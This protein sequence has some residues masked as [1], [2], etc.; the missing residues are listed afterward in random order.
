MGFKTSVRCFPRTF[1]KK[2][3]GFSSIFQC[4]F[5]LQFLYSMS[6]IAATRAEGGLVFY[7]PNPVTSECCIGKSDCYIGISECYIV[8]LSLQNVS[9]G[10]QKV[11]LLHQ[12]LTF[13]HQCQCHQKVILW[14]QNNTLKNCKY[15]CLRCFVFKTIKRTR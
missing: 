6:L 14:D 3:Q 9:L 1:H 12:N 13:R 5:V 7:P 2:F 8:T 11:A 15:L 4:S 10:L